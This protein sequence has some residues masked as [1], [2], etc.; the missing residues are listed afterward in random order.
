MDVNNKTNLPPKKSGGKELEQ[1]SSV[2][3]GE[4]QEKGMSCTQ[5]K[6]IHQGRVGE[7]TDAA[8]YQ[9]R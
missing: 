5:I 6:N 2:K 7:T 1:E 4:N 8:G 3:K 9:L